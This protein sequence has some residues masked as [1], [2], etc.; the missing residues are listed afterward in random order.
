M[1]DFQK[2]QSGNMIITCLNC[3]ENFENKLRFWLKTN[4]TELF[5]VDVKFINFKREDI[6]IFIN[7]ATC[8]LLFE[9]PLY[10]DV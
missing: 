1:H 10:L 7:Y 9:Y 6:M 3:C 5:L 8:S 4:I 2:L